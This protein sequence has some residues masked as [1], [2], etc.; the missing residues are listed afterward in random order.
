MEGGTDVLQKLAR[1]G[2]RVRVL[3][4]S[5]AANDVAAVHAGYAKRREPLLEAGVKVFELKRG[6]GEAAARG[7]PGGSSS[8]SLHAKTFAVDGAKVFVGSFNFDPRS[9]RLNTEMGLI[10][11]S[12]ELARRLHEWFDTRV[13]LLAYEVRRA[14]DGSLT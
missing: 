5:L 9:A 14:A 10:I 8:A 3:T 1:R 2:V 11:E 7:G 6:Q 4:N 13:P 12:P